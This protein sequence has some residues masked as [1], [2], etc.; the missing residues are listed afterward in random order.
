[1]TRQKSEFVHLHAHSDFSLLDGMTKVAD[2]VGR[3]KDY[4]MPALAITDPSVAAITA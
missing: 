2:M 3:A 4:G 1:M